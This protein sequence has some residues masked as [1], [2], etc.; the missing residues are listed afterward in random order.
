[1]II[2]GNFVPHPDAICEY[3]DLAPLCGDASSRAKEKKNLGVEEYSIFERLKD[4]D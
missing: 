2:T 1:V 4:F 3:C